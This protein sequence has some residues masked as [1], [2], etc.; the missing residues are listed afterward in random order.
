MIFMHLGVSDVNIGA[1]SSRREENVYI[2]VFEA[3]HSLVLV[4]YLC[5][6]LNRVSFFVIFKIQIEAEALNEFELKV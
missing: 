3:S 4:K 5:K 1:Q 2:Q 6:S